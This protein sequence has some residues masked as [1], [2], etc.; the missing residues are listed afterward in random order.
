M[1]CF[2]LYQIFLITLMHMLD[3]L[4]SS[5]GDRDGKAGSWLGSRG[6]INSVNGEEGNRTGQREE[7]SWEATQPGLLQLDRKQTWYLRWPLGVMQSWGK[8]T[9]VLCLYQ[10]L[11]EG[12]SKQRAG[13]EARWLTQLGKVLRYY[14][15]NP[16]SAARG[17]NV[18]LKT[19][20][21]RGSPASLWVYH[22]STSDVPS[23]C[24]FWEQSTQ[25][26]GGLSSW[27]SSRG[28]WMEGT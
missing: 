11:L 18:V 24:E 1:R 9:E 2:P 8:G 28:Y 6:Q 10:S 25:D 5:L 16:F 13:P 14:W 26:S 3:A 21:G 20:L 22:F 19:G 23:I 17:I 4:G 15:P 7:S 27:G 12:C